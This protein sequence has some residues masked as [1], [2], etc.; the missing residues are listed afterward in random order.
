MRSDAMEE[1]ASPVN[2]NLHN[3]N[4]STIEDNAF[5]DLTNINRLRLDNNRISSIKNITISGLTNLRELRIQ[6]NPFH[7]DCELI[8][9]VDFLKSG[10]VT[11]SGDPRCFTPENLN[12]ASLVSL[13]AANLTCP[14][15]TTMDTTTMDTTSMDTTTMDTTTMDTTTDETN[16]SPLKEGNVLVIVYLFLC[17]LVKSMMDF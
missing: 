3:N 8:G 13:S 6:D 9:L 17:L 11:V 15:T 10:R 5:R 12:G 1:I 7:C 14:D 16:S 2:R 4:I